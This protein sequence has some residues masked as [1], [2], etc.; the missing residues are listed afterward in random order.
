MNWII[1]AIP[2][3]QLLTLPTLINQSMV[4]IIDIIPATMEIAN[5]TINQPMIC[6]NMVLLFERTI[7]RMIPA[8]PIRTDEMVIKAE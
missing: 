2:A 3:I 5:I 8:T 7:A 4:K 1:N 6:L